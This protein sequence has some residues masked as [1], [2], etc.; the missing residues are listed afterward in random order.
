VSHAQLR[1]FPARAQAEPFLKQQVQESVTAG[2][3]AALAQERGDE[4]SGSDILRFS[5][6]RAAGVLVTRIDHPGRYV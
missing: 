2:A 6:Q 5:G 1:Q 4:V 3:V